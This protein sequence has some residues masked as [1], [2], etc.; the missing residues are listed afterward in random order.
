M[1]I[2]SCYELRDFWRDR[3]Q[4]PRPEIPL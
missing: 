3:G 1:A 2:W 4:A